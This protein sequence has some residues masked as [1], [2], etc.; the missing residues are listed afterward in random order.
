MNVL[1]THCLFIRDKNNNDE[2]WRK[3]IELSE[4]YL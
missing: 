1:F 2:R 3:F 4:V